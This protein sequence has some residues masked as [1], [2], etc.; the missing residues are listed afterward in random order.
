MVG[1]MSQE[2][3]GALMQQLKKHYGLNID[4]LTKSGILFA[5]GLL[6]LGFY[7]LMNQQQS[8]ETESA[9]S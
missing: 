6:F 4:L 3:N 7:F 5:T 8:V 1:M 2:S 9:S